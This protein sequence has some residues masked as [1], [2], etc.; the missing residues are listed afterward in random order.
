MF[1]KKFVFI[2]AA[3]SLVLSAVPARAQDNG[4]L[5]DLLVKKRIITDQEAE[6]GRAELTK[7]YAST[8]AAK[9]KLAMRA[10]SITTSARVASAISASI[11]SI[12]TS[13]SKPIST[14][15]FNRKLTC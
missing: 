15:N 8:S 1:A 7:E 3:A 13:S 12:A 14:S 6:E 10:R 11:L 9:M 2:A 4:A 5:L